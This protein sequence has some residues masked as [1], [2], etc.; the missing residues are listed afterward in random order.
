MAELRPMTDDDVEACAAVWNEAFSHMRAAA[1]A[2]VA[3]ASAERAALECRRMRH[4]LA[5]D[6]GGA[7][8]AEDGGGVVG[9]V[10]AIRRD[11]LWVL[12]LLAVAVA[13]QGQGLG[14][15]LFERALTYGSS[16]EPG[17]IVSSRDPRAIRCYAVA[18]FQ[19][20]PAVTALGPVRRSALPPVT[21]VT[22]APADA[23]EVA[24]AVDR[25][26][27]GASHGPDHAFLLGIGAR[28]LVA[29]DRGYAVV[30]EG[31]PLVLAALDDDSARRLL[32]TAL[33]EV[34]PG[35]EAE[36]HWMTAGQQWAVEVCVAAGLELRPVGPVMVRG[37]PG[38]L[39]PYIPSGAFG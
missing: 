38:A 2:V 3:P 25:R 36:V 5:T 19:L 24:A 26:I 37:R 4:L 12:S 30:R 15:S 32:V 11:G 23:L 17:I 7:W 27:R 33:A 18:G 28:L 21:G 8:V 1:G 6:P 29:G 39:S 35:C 22:E 31:A 10:Q 14:R 34:A 16:D 20:H 13:A 9:H